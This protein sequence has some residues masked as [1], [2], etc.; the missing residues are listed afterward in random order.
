LTSFFQASSFI[1]RIRHAVSLPATDLVRPSGLLAVAKPWLVYTTIYPL[2]MA[3]I[4]VIGTGYVGLTTGACFA[5]LGHT[6]VCVDIVPH[7]IELLQ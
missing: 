2:N 3:K 5:H 7:K 4:A 1:K 6:V